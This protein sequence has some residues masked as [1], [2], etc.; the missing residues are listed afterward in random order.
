MAKTATSAVATGHYRSRLGDEGAVELLH[1]NFTDTGAILPELRMSDV[2]VVPGGVGP[3]AE[4]V[5]GVGAPHVGLK[6][7]VLLVGHVQGTVGDRVVQSGE[8]I[9]VAKR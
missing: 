3:Q 8:A 9:L 4:V 6:R 7:C 1:C 2:R 5:V